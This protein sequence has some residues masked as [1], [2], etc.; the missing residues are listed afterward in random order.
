V[1]IVTITDS[2]GCSIAQSYT[3][4]TN[5]GIAEAD[6]ISSVTVYPNPSANIFHVQ[7]QLETAIEADLKVYNAL[8]KL[9]IEKKLESSNAGDIEIELEGFPSG[10]YYLDFKTA[11]D[12]KV[13]KMM[14]SF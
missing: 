1:Y 2:T 7:Y 11:T 14:K 3:V 13:M 4:G 8:G 12:R 9:I 6:S 5:V 10:I